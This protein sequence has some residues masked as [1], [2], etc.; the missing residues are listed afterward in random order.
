[1][2]PEEKEWDINFSL[3]QIV[4]RLCL[5]QIKTKKKS[6][7]NKSAKGK[8]HDST[9]ARIFAGAYVYTCEYVNINETL[10]VYN[11][12]IIVNL[13]SRLSQI[14]FHQVIDQKRY[15]KKDLIN[16]IPKITFSKVQQPKHCI[17]LWPGW[18][19]VTLSEGGE[20]FVSRIL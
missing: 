1:M 3:S 20:T 10:F 6:S 14:P 11:Q 16:Q 12:P 15:F 17:R 13:F 18:V 7:R 9:Q 19:V 5:E 8:L 2:R 4:G